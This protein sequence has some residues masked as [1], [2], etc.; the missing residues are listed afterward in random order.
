MNSLIENFNFFLFSDFLSVKWHIK[1]VILNLGF[2]ILTSLIL[3]LIKK[4]NKVIKIKYI[5]YVETIIANV[6][7]VV[8]TLLIASGIVAFLNPEEKIIN[9]LFWIYVSIIAGLLNYIWE[10]GNGTIKGQTETDFN[11][12]IS[13]ACIA[14]FS[15]PIFLVFML[16]GKISI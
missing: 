3:N 9:F 10:M 16:M 5:D 14:F 13:L 6:L 8:S 11:L 7:A 12:F 1:M 2:A 4:N 15:T